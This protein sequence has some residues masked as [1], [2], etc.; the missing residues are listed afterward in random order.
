MPDATASK[1]NMI[2]FFMLPLFSLVIGIGTGN[3]F[4]LATFPKFPCFTTNL[5]L[6]VLCPS[7]AAKAAYEAAAYHRAKNRLNCSRTDIRQD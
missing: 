1:T 7:A 3:I 2:F 4:T 6:D 5:R